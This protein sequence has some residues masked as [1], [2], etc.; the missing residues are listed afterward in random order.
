MV[1][2]ENRRT[3]NPPFAPLCFSQPHLLKKKKKKEKK[4]TVKIN[5]PNSQVASLPPTNNSLDQ[6]QMEI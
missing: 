4:V 5:N 2:E 1:G 6:Y 3:Q